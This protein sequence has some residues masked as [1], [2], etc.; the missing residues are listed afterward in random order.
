MSLHHRSHL[1]QAAWDTHDLRNFHRAWSN[2]CHS[3][4]GQLLPALYQTQCQIF[5]L[6]DSESNCQNIGKI[7][8]VSGRATRFPAEWHSRQGGLD[9]QSAPSEVLG[10]TTRVRHTRKKR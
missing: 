5:L 9:L 1:S 2:E 3:S 6:W 10:Q 4:I 7:N 8:S